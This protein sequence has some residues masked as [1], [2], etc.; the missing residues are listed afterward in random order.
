MKATKHGQSE[1]RICSILNCPYFMQILTQSF[2]NVVVGGFCELAYIFCWVYFKI[3]DH[4][5]ILQSSENR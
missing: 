4:F 2:T 5:A 3:T 1:L